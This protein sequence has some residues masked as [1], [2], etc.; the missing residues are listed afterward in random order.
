MTIEKL[1]CP[2]CGAPHPI[3]KEEEFSVCSFCA[4]QLRIRK[5]ETGASSLELAELKADLLEIK[6]DHQLPVLEKEFE[7]KKD[8]LFKLLR[9]AEGLSVELSEKQ[10]KDIRSKQRRAAVFLLT[11]GFLSFL[12]V[13]LTTPGV[14]GSLLLGGCGLFFIGMGIYGLLRIPSEESWQKIGHPETELNLREKEE[15]IRWESEK[16][17]ELDARISKLK[18]QRSQLGETATPENSKN[19]PNQKSGALNPD[20]FPFYELAQGAKPWLKKR[21]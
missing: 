12:I 6:I 20:L 1:N 18:T 3:N 5:S 13:I 21:F 7:Q 16:I 14:F 15:N 2:A 19:L 9:E 8:H 10:Q 4:S 11:F 17:I